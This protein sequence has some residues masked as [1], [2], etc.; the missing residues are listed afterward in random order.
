VG[1]WTK[2]M[3]RYIPLEIA[4]PVYIGLTTPGYRHHHREKGRLKASS[5]NVCHPLHGTPCGLPANLSPTRQP[6]YSEIRNIP[7][8]STTNETA[9]KPAPVKREEP[10]QEYPPVSNST[11]DVNAIPVHKPSGKP[12]TQVDI[13]KGKLSLR[14]LSLLFTLMHTN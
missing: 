10:R 11:V 9:V 12:I 1:K 14:S 6:R 8:R 13:D 3:I 2:M 5:F 4:F 7:Q